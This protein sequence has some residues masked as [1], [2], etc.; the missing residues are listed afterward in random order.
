[1]DAPPLTSLFL[2][3]LGPQ[4]AALPP[5]VRQLHALPMPVELRGRA[6]AQ[7]ARGLPARLCAFVAGLP[8]ADGEVSVRVRFASPAAGVAVWTRV[9]GAS[10]FDSADYAEGRAAFAERRRPAFTGL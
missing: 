6:H 3:L 9:F 4:A 8:R 7:S 5:R 1:M 2:D 10:T